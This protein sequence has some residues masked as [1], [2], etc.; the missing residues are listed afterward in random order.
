MSLVIPNKILRFLIGSAISIPNMQL[1]LFVSM[2][3]NIHLTFGGINY[4]PKFMAEEVIKLTVKYIVNPKF[5]VKLKYIFEWQYNWITY[6]SYLFNFFCG[7]QWKVT[8]KYPYNIPCAHSTQDLKFFINCESWTVKCSTFMF[9]IRTVSLLQVAT[10]SFRIHFGYKLAN[11]GV[12]PTFLDFTAHWKKPIKSFYCYSHHIIIAIN[13]LFFCI[14]KKK[15]F[16]YKSWK[17]C[18]CSDFWDKLFTSRNS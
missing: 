15:Y 11:Y 3:Q 5:R 10:N 18:T 12:L 17:L 9:D 16:S 6:N 1:H 8:R 14:L 2:L 4:Q 13:V 7:L